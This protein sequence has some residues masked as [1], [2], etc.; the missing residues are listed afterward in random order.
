MKTLITA[1]LLISFTLND[2]GKI[3]FQNVSSVFE[4]AENPCFPT[5]EKAEEHLKNY[6]AKGQ[7]IEQLKTYGV[8]IDHKAHEIVRALENESD[9]AECQKLINNLEFLSEES[10]YSYSIYKAANHYFIVRYRILANN[11]FKWDSTTINNSK[12]EVI[13]VALN[14][15]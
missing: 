14:W 13:A 5:H 10:E 1:L 12:F 8:E 6:L 15:Y 11:E 9:S 7:N 3:P 4:T 2:T